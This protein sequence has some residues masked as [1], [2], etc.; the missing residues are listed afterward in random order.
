MN[1]NV[2]EKRAMRQRKPEILFEDSDLLVCRKPSGVAVETA[3]TGQMDLV[4]LLKNYR[5]ERGEPP[6]IAPVHRLDQPVEG[7][8]VFAENRKT[9]AAL[10]RQVQSGD[11]GKDYLALVC[12][13]PGK[14]QGK[15]VQ[16]LLRNGRKNYSEIVPEGTEGAKKAVLTYEL[17]S[18]ER[19]PDLTDG[20][21]EG[22]RSIPEGCSLLLIHLLTGRHHQIRVQ[23]AGAG[24]PV[25]ADAKYGT[26]VPGRAIALCAYHLQFVHPRTKRKMNFKICPEW[27]AA[28]EPEQL[29]S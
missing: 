24:M 3:R 11:W 21:A 17:V 4:S 25:Y 28:S 27:L 20:K 19:L 29:Y 10:G 22:K 16:Y 26:A 7:V 18:G 15:L 14:A 12:G 13:K 9:A 6:Y 8:M 2:E 1:R 5:A 23:L